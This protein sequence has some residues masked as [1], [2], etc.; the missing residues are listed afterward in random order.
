M[1]ELNTPSLNE[2]KVKVTEVIV[3][4]YIHSIRANNCGPLQHIY[5]EFLKVETSNFVHI[6]RVKGP[7]QKYA[8]VA[9]KE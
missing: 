1:Q 9:Q 5:Q 4:I 3:I 7:N 6:S 2:A 8:K